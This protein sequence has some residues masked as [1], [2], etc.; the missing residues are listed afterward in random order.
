[1]A[2][3]ARVD[4]TLVP[5]ASE[6][7]HVD[8]AARTLDEQLLQNALVERYGRAELE[9]V[10]SGPGLVNIHRAL[11][12]HRC[13]TLTEPLESTGFPSLITRAALEVGCPDCRATLETFVS[14]YGAAAGNLA[15]TTLSTGGVF[16]AGG[17]A[18]R[19]LPALRWPVFMESFL[20]KS[21]MEG[22]MRRIPVSV[23]MNPSAGL[24]GAAT[25]ASSRQKTG[26]H[27]P[28]GDAG[29]PL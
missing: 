20:A 14:V 3:L 17:I 21:P 23:I 6:G 29:R 26:V 7:G 18:P 13:G 4:G 9:R 27:P 2:L 19:I 8:F 16:L 1:M 5:L 24:V 15:L 12:P 25:F 10:V 22:L 11:R 28:G